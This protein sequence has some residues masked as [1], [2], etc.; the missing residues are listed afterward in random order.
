[1]DKKSCEKMIYIFSQ[2]FMDQSMFV[3]WNHVRC[4]QGTILSAF[5][6]FCSGSEE[7]VAGTVEGGFAGIFQYGDNETYTYHLHGNIIAD[8]EGC[9]GNRNEEQGAA[10]YAGCTAGTNGRNDAEQKGRSH[11][12]FNTQGMG[13]SQSQHGNGNGCA[14]HVDGGTQRDGNGEGI[15]IQ[16]QSLAEG[17]VHR[18]VGSRA[19]GEESIDTA[20]TDGGPYQGI[21][22]PAYFG[23]YDK[24]IHHQGY[25][26]VGAD[27]DAQ[28]LYIAQKSTL[29]YLRNQLPD[30]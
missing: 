2:L 24:G 14:G 8:A 17:Q 25:Q 21:G 22:V 4:F 15:R 9:A 13:S 23:K 26:E 16:S 3:L 28:Q 27:E 5:C 12:Y 18:N 29:R 7:H 20:F 1:M 19:S 11:I 6:K 10:G 30:P